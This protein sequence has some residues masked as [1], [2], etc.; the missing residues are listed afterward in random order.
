M[1]VGIPFSILSEEVL[2]QVSIGSS[3]MLEF[4]LHRIPDGYTAKISS[5][6]YQDFYYHG[7]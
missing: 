3:G 1:S 2:L 6:Y 7:E 5:I 4:G